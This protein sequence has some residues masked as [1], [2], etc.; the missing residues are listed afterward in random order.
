M[1]VYEGLKDILECTQVNVYAFI[2][3]HP[4][5]SVQADSDQKMEAGIRCS[6]PVTCFSP[7]RREPART[8]HNL[9]PN[10]DAVFLL[11]NTVISGEF[12]PGFH[13]K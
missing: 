11:P 3:S 6:Y 12:P 5:Q 8:K 7:F 4:G 9:K 1:K 2:F 10:M 13:W